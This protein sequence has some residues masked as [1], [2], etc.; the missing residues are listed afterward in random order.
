VRIAGEAYQVKRQRD[1]F[2]KLY[3]ELEH[4]AGLFIRAALRSL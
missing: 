1:G 2:L 3:R 4:V